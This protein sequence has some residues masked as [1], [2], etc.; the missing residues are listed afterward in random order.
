MSSNRLTLNKTSLSRE[1]QR[2][3]AFSQFLPSLDLKRRQLMAARKEHQAKQKKLQAEMDALEAEVANDLPMLGSGRIDCS[4][5]IWVE[6]VELTFENL[7]GVKLPTV[8]NVKLGKKPYAYLGMPHWVDHLIKLLER[9]L[10]LRMELETG[11][12]RLALLEEAL[13][14]TTQRFNLLDKVLIP[15]AQSNI[16]RINLFLAD[17][18]RAEVV[19]AKI[20]KQ[21][22]SGT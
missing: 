8:V 1:Q 14:R 10:R 16:K 22:R 3:K 4:G 18:M 20:S 7:V 12:R 9:A 6:D 2:L 17:Q 5:L 19:R 15:R 13:Q 21:K 11:A